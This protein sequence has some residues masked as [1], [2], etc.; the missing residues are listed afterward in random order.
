MK[1]NK[2]INVARELMGNKVGIAAVIILFLITLASILAFLSTKN[3]DQ[4]NALA[5][6]QPP[7][8]DHWFGTDDYGRDTFTRA[9]YGGRVSL[10]VGFLSMIFATVI[11]VTVGVISGYFGG[12]I[13]SLLMRFLDIIMS[14]PSFLILLLL[15]V[16]LKPSVGNIIVIISLLMWMSIAR[17]VRAETMA[18]KE[19]EY[20]LYAKASGQ[21]TFGIIWK[22]ILPGLLSVVI[23]SATNN[24]A[25][26]IMM[27]SSLSFLG[28]GVQTPKATWGS[29]LNGAQGYIAQAPYMALFP[30][31]LIFLTVLCFNILGDILR[32][33][34]EP[35]LGKR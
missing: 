20:V 4:M 7:S 12:L 26:A 16:Y 2:W 22:H 32:I 1:R 18:L 6:L 29:M 21:S 35:K 30:G 15:S 25:S 33:G 13:D 14:I 24:I 19:R 9:L 5:R 23:V 34:L 27:E 31:L 3:P 10:S 11:G 8:R 28:F 17:V